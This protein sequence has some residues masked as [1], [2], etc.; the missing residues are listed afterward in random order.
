MSKGK[1]ERKGYRIAELPEEERPVNRLHE[2][3]PR[4][5]SSAELV[6]CILQTGDA[7]C[8]ANDLL[9]ALGGLEG[10]ANAE[11]CELVE[12]EGIGAARAAQVLA[13]LELGRRVMTAQQEERQQVRAPSDAAQALMPLLS[14]A[15][16]EHFVVVFLDTRNRIIDQDVLYKGSLN[17]SLVRIA[18][19]FRGAARRNCAAIIVAHNHPS[20]DPSPSPEDV[21]LTR[22]LVE[23][24]QLEIEVLDHLVIGRNRYLSMRERQL[25]FD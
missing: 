15:E 12:V 20:G 21:A 18:E 11:L 3:G 8:Q 7:L 1:Q 2:V 10:L 5:V 4:G 16:Q 6:A 14:Y 24:G 25:G 23:A 9:V 17:T 19:V 13:A 22:R